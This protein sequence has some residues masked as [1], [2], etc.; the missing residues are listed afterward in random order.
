MVSEVEREVFKVV[1][2]EVCAFDRDALEDGP[3]EVGDLQ[4][5][6][7]NWSSPCVGT[8]FLKSFFFFNF[9][10]FSLF[11]LIQ[12]Q[13]RNNLNILTYRLLYRLHIFII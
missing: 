8:L 2:L 7:A 10:L 11:S 4:D 1:A 13:D 9:T 5:R 6:T 12:K 3:C